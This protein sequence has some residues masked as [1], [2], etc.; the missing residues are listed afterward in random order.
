MAKKDKSGKSD[1]NVMVDRSGVRFDPKMHAATA[2][3]TPHADSAGNFI[4]KDHHYSG[5]AKQ[6]YGDTYRSE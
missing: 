5:P 1:V 4:L 2:D 6:H 3:G